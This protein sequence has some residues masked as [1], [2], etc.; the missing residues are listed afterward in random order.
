MPSNWQISTAKTCCRTF[1]LIARAE[2]DK[3]MFQVNYKTS[4]FTSFLYLSCQLWTNSHLTSC[5]CF[6]VKSRQLLIW[7]VLMIS[8]QLL[9]VLHDV[10]RN[11]IID[12]INC[13]LGLELFLIDSF[14]K[15]I[16]IRR[17]CPTC[18]H[19]SYAMYNIVPESVVLTV[20]T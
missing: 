8:F 9:V 7:W 15:T 11:L 17:Y 14:Q 16:W 5:C 1:F 20:N 18:L 4:T 19:W 12:F 2:A 10:K 3:N 6:F 13:D